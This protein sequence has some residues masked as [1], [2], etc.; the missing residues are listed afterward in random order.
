VRPRSGTFRCLIG[1]LASLAATLVVLG[2]ASPSQTDGLDLQLTWESPP[3]CPDLASERTEISRRAGNI[4]RADQPV[5]AKGVIRADPS[6]GYHMML[7]TRV[8]D[9][10][11]ERVLAGPDCRQLAEAAALVLA[12]LISPEAGL[13][14][15]HEPAKAAPTPALTPPP[16]ATGPSYRFGLGLG[17]VL[18]SGVLPSPAAGLLAR[19][20]YRRGVLLLAQEIAGFLPDQKGAPVLPG[21]SAS[22]YRLEAALQL[23][24]TTPHGRRLGGTACLGGAVVRLHGQSSGVSNPG[25]ATAYWPEALLAGSGRLRLTAATQLRL[26]LELRRLGSRPDFDILGLGSTFRPPAYN[27]R[28]IA[29]LDL[30]F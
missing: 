29:G 13:S 2:E 20:D 7:W 3:G 12:L 18:A 11:G 17:A 23:C 25:Q 19:V 5:T 22:F 15:E 16:A 21:A 1:A 28:G 27:V 4:G 6:D 26:A 10:M 30:H 8:G 9:T 24:A 14:S